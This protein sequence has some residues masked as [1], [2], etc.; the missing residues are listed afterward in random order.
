MVSPVPTT[1]FAEVFH[2]QL[3]TSTF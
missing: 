2:Q 1:Q 3:N